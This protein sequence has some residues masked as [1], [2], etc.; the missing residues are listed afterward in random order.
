M[1]RKILNNKIRLALFLLL[2]G[3]LV[4]IRAFEDQLFYDPFLDFFKNDF[5]NLPLPVY[6]SLLLFGG[7]LFRYGLNSI[8][9]LGII[10]VLFKEIEMVKFASILYIVFFLILIIIFFAIL[11]INVEH[12][13]L[14]LFY[15]R[16]FLI[17]PIFVLL[18]VP[19]F[20]YQKQN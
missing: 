8:I 6:D 18:F 14:T 13:Y 10:Y 3:L 12:H 2:V 7:L 17:Q 4:L 1:L 5:T 15:V 20:F 19:G 16:R 9:S 11:F